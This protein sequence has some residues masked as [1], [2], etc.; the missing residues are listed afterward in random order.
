[1]PDLARS[2]LTVAIA[3]IND[4]DDLCTLRTIWHPASDDAKAV[5]MEHFGSGESVDVASSCRQKLES[6]DAVVA[7]I[8]GPAGALNVS[9]TID[10]Y[11][12]GVGWDQ[13]EITVYTDELV[14][15]D[16]VDFDW[17]GSNV[18]YSGP[19]VGLIDKDGVSTVI[20]PFMLK[21]KCGT[22]KN[23]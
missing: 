14:T 13:I 4:I 5:M 20:F 19:S 21:L 17:S 8:A 9:G 23:S 22:Q 2:D 15:L 12:V 11:N 1:M 6:C 7:L 16:S 18:Q 10:V 3:D